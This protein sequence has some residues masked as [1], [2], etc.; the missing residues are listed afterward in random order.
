MTNDTNFFDGAMGGA[1]APRAQLKNVNDFVQGEIVDMFERDYIGFG[2]TEPEKRS[3]GSIKQQLV[4]ILQTTHKN[5]ENVNTVPRVDYKDPNSAEKAPSEDDGKRAIYV[6][7]GKN[8]Q[9][10]IGRAI[11]ASKAPFKVGGRLGV[12]ITNL[13]DTGKG[14][15]LK[16]HAAHYEGPSEASGFFG[17]TEQAAPA[18]PA[19]QA[20]PA[21]PAQQA[22]PAP[23]APATQD[24]W[25]TS[26]AQGGSQPPF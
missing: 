24:P 5:W 19:Q 4:I 17:G 26:P 2:K 15:P 12:K 21:A 14:N 6:P 20:A 8:I 11:S 22:A 25:A 10:A 3:D 16:E 18:A 13:K 23:Q 9:Y 1:G 7:E